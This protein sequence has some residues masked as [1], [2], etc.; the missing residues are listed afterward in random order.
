MTLFMYINSSNFTC[1]GKRFATARKSHAFFFL[2][3]TGPSCAV[4]HC[5]VMNILYLVRTRKPSQEKSNFVW[6]SLPVLLTLMS[7]TSRNTSKLRQVIIWTENV[8]PFQALM[9]QLLEIRDGDRKGYQGRGISMTLQTFVDPDDVG[10][11]IVLHFLG[12]HGRGAAG[13]CRFQTSHVFRASD[14][15]LVLWFSR[16][17]PHRLS[18]KAGTSFLAL[19]LNRQKELQMLPRN[20]LF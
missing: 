2:F 9:F 1:Y 12:R 19:K 4:D 8:A 11:V 15:C 7:K 16:D 18:G 17:V 14:T 6:M 3:Y 13:F 20:L 5:L 10:A